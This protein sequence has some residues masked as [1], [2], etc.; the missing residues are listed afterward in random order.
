M[1]APLACSTWRSSH[2]H[3]RQTE[4]SKS[5]A[6][7]IWI[8]LLLSKYRWETNQQE[9]LAPWT[10]SR[11]PVWGAT[12]DLSMKSNAERSLII[13]AKHI[14]S[15]RS[16]SLSTTR[17]VQEVSRRKGSGSVVI[18]WLTR[19]NRSV[20]GRVP[21]SQIN[22]A[23]HCSS[24]WTRWLYFRR[25][26]SSRLPKTRSFQ[27]SCFTSK[28]RGPQISKRTCDRNPIIALISLR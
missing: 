16:S 17:G 25:R 23:R 20:L 22:S 3:P 11:P 1:I 7:Q 26:P 18:N 21:K 9:G 6:F 28:T 5:T 8:G 4:K 14:R 12:W 2:C 15:W 10:L 24:L 19:N 27:I 13:W